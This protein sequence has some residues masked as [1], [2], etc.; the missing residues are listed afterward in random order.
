RRIEPAANRIDA[1][2]RIRVERRADREGSRASRERRVPGAD[3]RYGNVRGEC[4]AG[5]D[6]VQVLRKDAAA[7]E[8]A[9]AAEDRVLMSEVG[10]DVGVEALLAHVAPTDE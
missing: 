7:R 3:T 6:V 1:E 9:L 8:A 10:D 5:R 2:L 4:V